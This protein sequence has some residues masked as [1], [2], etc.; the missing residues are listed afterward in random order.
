MLYSI[1]RYFIQ[2]KFYADEKRE[3]ERER[4]KK[5]N[6]DIILLLLLEVKVS[7]FIITKYQQ[8]QE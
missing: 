6:S 7:N 4:Q 1:L 3:K 2:S 5:H 8:E